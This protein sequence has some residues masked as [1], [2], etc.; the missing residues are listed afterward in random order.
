MEFKRFARLAVGSV[1]LLVSH[2]L[3]SAR[4]ADRIV[5]LDEGRLVEQGTHA[6][7]LA[8]DGM[9]ARMWR[10]Q[11]NWYSRDWVRGRSL[12]ND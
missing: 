11:A 7:L 12:Q 5:V 3:G 8:L 4:L 1:A 2:R 6:E 10:E 9:Y